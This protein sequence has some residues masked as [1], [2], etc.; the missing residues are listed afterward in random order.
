MSIEITK[1]KVTQ[2]IANKEADGNVK[3]TGKYEL[4]S[5]KGDVIAKQT[6][7]GYDDMKIEFE[8]AIG[9]DFLEGVESTIELEMGIQETLK[10]IKENK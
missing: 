7:N 9:K 2:A 6:F 5:T 1:V 4:I 8:K 10:K 3:I